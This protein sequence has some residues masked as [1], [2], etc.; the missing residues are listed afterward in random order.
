MTPDVLQQ[1][2]GKARASKLAKLRP[3]PADDDG[4][5][6]DEKKG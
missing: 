4:E 3:A 6:T 2:L 5:K 1:H